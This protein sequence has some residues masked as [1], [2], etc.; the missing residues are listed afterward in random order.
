MRDVSVNELSLVA[1]L[2]L[3][4]GWPYGATQR[5]IRAA[6]DWW[7]CSWRHF[8]GSPCEQP[9]EYIKNWSLFI[10]IEYRFKYLGIMLNPIVLSDTDQLAL[11][12][13]MSVWSRIWFI[14]SVPN[15]NSTSAW[16][17]SSETLRQLP[18]WCFSS[19]WISW[20]SLVTETV[21]LGFIW[22]LP[23]VHS[24]F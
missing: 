19:D 5:G 6:S 22:F 8:C 12:W 17:S 4:W 3:I 9:A 18:V 1:R 16:F 11:L 7:S 23:V 21:L 14:S 2:D 13:D 10:R 20:I 24:G 15:P